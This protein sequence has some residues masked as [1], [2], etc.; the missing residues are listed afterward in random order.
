MKFVFLLCLDFRLETDLGERFLK[1]YK[2]ALKEEFQQEDILILYQ[3][4]KSL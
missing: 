2:E 3:E 4:M 1:K